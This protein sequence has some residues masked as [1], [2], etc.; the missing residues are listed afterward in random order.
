MAGE[1]GMGRRR[2]TAMAGLM[3]VAV[4]TVVTG[5]TQAPMAMSYPPSAEKRIQSVA[6]WQDLAESIADRVKALNSARPVL[7]ETPAVRTAFSQA[8]H[9][10]LTTRLVEQGVALAGPDATGEALVLRYSSQVV[11][12]AGDRYTRPQP[13]A[14]TGLAAAITL[15]AYLARF[16]FTP[17]E[18]AG[19]GLGAAALADVAL[20]AYTPTTNTEL[21][22]ATQLSEDGRIRFQTADN[23]YIND[24]DSTH[25]EPGREPVLLAR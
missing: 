16:T 23:F 5:C 21:I 2:A 22:I 19:L 25:Y 18:L 17:L 9:T 7:V 4:A 13:G 10:Y 3:M 1:D 12:H 11:E 14:L 20:G 6:H 8:F 24:R 15:P